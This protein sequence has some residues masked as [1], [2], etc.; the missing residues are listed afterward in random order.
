MADRGVFIADPESS[1]PLKP[2]L[3]FP[4]DREQVALDS[5]LFILL[6]ILRLH[7][8]LDYIGLNSMMADE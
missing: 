8:Y 7:Q 1:V 5:P 2:K 4:H 6:I 3:S